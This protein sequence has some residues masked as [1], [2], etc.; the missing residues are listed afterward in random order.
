MD[1]HQNSYIAFDISNGEDGRIGWDLY[2]RIGSGHFFSTIVYLLD[3]DGSVIASW[4]WRRFGSGTEGG[5]GIAGA[6]AAASGRIAITGLDQL[7]DT[8]VLYRSGSFGNA[9]IRNDYTLLVLMV[10]N[11]AW[12]GTFSLVRNSHATVE[13]ITMGPAALLSERDF[14]GG[15]TI[16]A[17]VPE[18]A[19][20]VKLYHDAAYRGDVV[21]RLFG[22]FEGHEWAGTVQMGFMG[23]D[24]MVREGR[25]QYDFFGEPAGLYEWYLWENTDACIGGDCASGASDVR[26]IFAD[27]TRP[28]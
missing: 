27:V 5:V 19:A 11:G 16:Y 1:L 18:E 23:P 7:E 2:S 21:G 8:R 26:L 10:G 20:G 3:T 9:P 24:G 28:G 12:N 4:Q 17:Q 22:T 6:G 14:S 15:T 13:A 25:R